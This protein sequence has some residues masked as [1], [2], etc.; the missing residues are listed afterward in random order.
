[1]TC[2]WPR[3]AAANAAVVLMRRGLLWPAVAT[4]DLLR[5]GQPRSRKVRVQPHSID[6]GCGQR[7]NMMRERDA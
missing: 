2:A 4:L 6:S 5:A 7:V 1:M 3:K